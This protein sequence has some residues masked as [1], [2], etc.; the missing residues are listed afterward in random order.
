MYITKEAKS[1]SSRDTQTE[2]YQKMMT[3]KYT[4]FVVELLKD[5]QEIDDKF[6]EI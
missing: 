5:M 1:V 2:R 6:T 4:F 3:K